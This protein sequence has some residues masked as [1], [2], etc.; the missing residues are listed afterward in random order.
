MSFRKLA[1]ASEFDPPTLKVLLEAFAPPRVPVAA[2][3]FSFFESNSSFVSEFRYG[4]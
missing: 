3:L 4:L 2:V 1:L